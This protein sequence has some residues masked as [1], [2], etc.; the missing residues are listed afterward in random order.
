MQK[1]KQ[2]AC[3][4]QKKIKTGF[5]IVFKKIWGKAL[6]KR[7]RARMSNNDWELNKN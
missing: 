1:T 2:S 6:R 5:I 7:K 3:K 4:R